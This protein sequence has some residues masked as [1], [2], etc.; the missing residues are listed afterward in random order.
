MSQVKNHSN[1]FRRKTIGKILKVISLGESL[2]LIGL[3]GSGKSYL[4]TSLSLNQQV[5]KIIPYYLDWNLLLEKTPTNFLKIILT[6]VC[7]GSSL[8]KK[9]SLEKQLTFCFEKIF[10]QDNK[11]VVLIFDEFGSLPHLQLK[12]AYQLL[13]SF[14]NQYKNKLCFIFGTRLPIYGSK[15]LKKFGSFATIL[16]ENLVHLPSLDFNNT[17]TF[18]NILKQ[19]IN[20]KVTP[21]Q[22][23]KI[24]RLSGGHMRTI[25]NLV[26]L[27]AKN[28]N[29]VKI[30]YSSSP[31]LVYTF[32]QILNYLP[33]S[34]LELINLSGLTPKQLELLKRLRIITPTG[35]P[36]TKLLFKYLTKKYSPPGYQESVG[37]D[38][39]LLVQLTANEHHC[40]RYLVQNKDQIITR[41]KLI[42]TIWGKNASLAISN[43]ALDQLIFRLKKK[44]QAATKPPV[45]L[46]TIR[47]RGHRLT[48]KKNSNTP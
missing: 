42:E 6:K 3:P 39:C 5:N 40:F 12:S 29:L 36:R 24:Y 1:R 19:Q 31:Q 8:K 33:I 20:F 32:E 2:Q 35:Q 30:D 25:R 41:E 21:A 46:E 16:Q 10:N 27:L 17:L 47:G 9:L 15:N 13:K 4:L 43:H 28:K 48:I 23:K 7:P 44:L 45:V 22:T 14:Q 37:Q 34:P 38:L 11:K 18:I 26:I